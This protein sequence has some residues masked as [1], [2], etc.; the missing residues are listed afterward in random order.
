MIKSIPDEYMFGTAF[1]VNPVTQRMYS[2]PDGK[3]IRKARKVYLPKSSDWY[4]FWTGKKIKGGQIVDAAAPIETIPLFIKEGSIVP[5][6]PYMQYA[7]EKAA[8]TVEL[9]IYTGADAG[10]VL[11]ED[12]NDNY[13]YEHGMYSTIKMSWTEA[14]KDF[15]IGDRNGDFPG[16]VKDRIFRVVWVDSKSGKGL[17]PAKKSQNIHYSGKEIKIKYKI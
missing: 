7:T 8:D 3:T 5:M 10:F 1:L 11:Y 9:R 17:E 2:L 13:N 15:T 4:D 14:E 6:G 12:E 16:M